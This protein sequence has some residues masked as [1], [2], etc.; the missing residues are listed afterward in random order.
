MQGLFILFK[1]NLNMD[2]DG[3]CW[4]LTAV[5]H[6]GIW[7]ADMVDHLNANCLDFQRMIPQ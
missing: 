2:C 5:V 1:D 3:S 7:P 4:R 6:E